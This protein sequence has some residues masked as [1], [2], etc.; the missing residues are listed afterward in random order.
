MTQ[1][2]T[3]YFKIN[4]NTFKWI[5][6]GLLALLFLGLSYFSHISNLDY[7]QIDQ[8]SYLMGAIEL[9]NLKSPLKYFTG[10]IKTTGQHPLYIW[11]CSFFSSKEIQ[12]FTKAKFLSNF[13][14]LIFYLVLGGL[15]RKQYGFLVSVISISILI[16]SNE[17]IRY[18]SWVGCEYLLLTFTFLTWYFVTNGFTNQKLWIFGGGFNGLAYMSK[19][20]GFLFL[21]S[22]I[23]SYFIINLKNR[24]LK[25]SIK[26]KYFYLYLITFMLTSSPLLIRN[27]IVHKNPFYNWNQKIM[28]LDRKP[29]WRIRDL[30]EREKK[31]KDST[32]QNYLKK[33]GVKK[34]IRRLISGCKSQLSVFV[35]SLGGVIY[36]TG[37]NY[38]VLNIII[39]STLWIF[40]FIFL[41]KDR[42]SERRIYNFVLFCLFYLIIAFLTPVL[43]KQ[44]R[45]FMPI[46]SIFIIYAAICINN[47]LIA[48]IARFKP[49]RY[50]SNV[51]ELM[52][53]TLLLGFIL[54]KVFINLDYSKNPFNL[55]HLYQK[56]GY[57]VNSS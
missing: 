45:F 26:N 25:D 20:T 2:S 50:P 42:S 30:A 4:K 40:A 44:Y 19:P 56:N 32:M 16:T 37:P 41:L 49:S 31:Y 33:N 7:S 8:E 57:L 22:F 18:L 27:I 3:I 13:L 10:S 36:I 38:Y 51:I 23:I 17:Y 39:N 29:Y 14:G 48:A 6:L 35:L 1:S 5:V 21:P 9:S 24:S 12:F 34:I 46:N 15:I 28:W 52:I 43:T 47:L 54:L 11:L 55:N 53:I